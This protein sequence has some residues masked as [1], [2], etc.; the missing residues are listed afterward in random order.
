MSLGCFRV[1]LKM[2]NGGCVWEK[3]GLIFNLSKR[4][5][6]NGSNNNNNNCK[7]LG[8]ILPFFFFLQHSQTLL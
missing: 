4:R 2:N 3:E 8:S 5:D 7:F 1:S 6:N